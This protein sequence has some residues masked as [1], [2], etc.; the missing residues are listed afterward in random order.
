MI[1]LTFIIVS[2]CIIWIQLYCFSIHFFL[3][4]SAYCSNFL[5][6]LPKNILYASEYYPFNGMNNDY[7][8]LVICK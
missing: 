1:I 6:E 7:N 2:P 3:I 8:L 5:R 4:A